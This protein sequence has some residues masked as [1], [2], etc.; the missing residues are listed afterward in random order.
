MCDDAHE[1]ERPGPAMKAIPV[2]QA[3]GTI[4]A[5]DI[6]EIRSGDMHHEETL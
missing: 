1:S 2:G 4:L 5:H 6:T 3:V